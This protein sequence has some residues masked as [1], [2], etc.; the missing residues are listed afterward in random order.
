MKGESL[1]ETLDDFVHDFGALEHLTFDGFQYQVGKNTKFFKNIWK[2]NIDHH[3]SAPRHPN[4]NPAEGAI[5]EL[6]RRFYRV[7]QQMK[8]PKRVWDYLVLWICE[9]GNL[10]VSIWSYGKG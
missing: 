3:V 4:E 8:I 5:T 1:G 6:K 9:T 7:M 2:Y 10:Y